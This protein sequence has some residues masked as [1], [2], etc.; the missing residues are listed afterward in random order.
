VTDAIDKGFWVSKWFDCPCVDMHLFDGEVVL[1]QKILIAP[2]TQEQ[3]AALRVAV[4]VSGVELLVCNG[5]VF[6]HE[7]V[8]LT[9]PDDRFLTGKGVYLRLIRDPE[10]PANLVLPKKVCVSVKRIAMVAAPSCLPAPYLP[11]SSK[12]RSR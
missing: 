2:L 8:P 12:V 1:P 5:S 10:A 6:V 3:G 9:T 7:T 11:L 4:H